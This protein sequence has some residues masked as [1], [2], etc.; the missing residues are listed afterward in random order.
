MNYI[1]RQKC[2]GG[3]SRLFCFGHYGESLQNDFDI[4]IDIEV[5][6]PDIY[7]YE[8]LDDW[9]LGSEGKKVTLSKLIL[10]ILQLFILN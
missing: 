2:I 5:F 10:M 7:S 4:N 9:F 1:I 6:D 3:R 8:V